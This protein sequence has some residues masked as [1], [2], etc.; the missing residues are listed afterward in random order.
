MANERRQCTATSKRSQERCKRAPTP[1]SGVC[2]MH[3]SAS[4]Q[5]RRKAAE[6]LATEEIHARISR[7]T[8]TP[9]TDPFRAFQEYAGRVLAREKVIAEAVENI[10][11]WRYTSATGEQRRAELG[12]LET[13]MA[14][15]RQTLS[16]LARLQ[17][18]ERIVQI[19]E[20][21]ADV[22]SAVLATVFRK[23]K[24]TPEMVIEAEQLVAVELVRA[25]NAGTQTRTPH[26]A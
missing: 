1:G 22:F 17:L 26:T 5:A 23:L 19:R 6:R 11:E 21:E 2:R 15:S 20:K 9:V 10:S 4:P 16:A 24:L 3:G 13:I 25:I 8:A 7:T 14:E 12:M 18:D